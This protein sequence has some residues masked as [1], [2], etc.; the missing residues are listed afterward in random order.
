MYI[1]CS[2]KQGFG[3]HWF[4]YISFPR[5]GN[6]RIKI[7]IIKRRVRTKNNLYSPILICYQAPKFQ[8]FTY[9]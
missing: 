8:N 5:L 4:F 9:K 6:N 1:P 3:F 7:V 2:I